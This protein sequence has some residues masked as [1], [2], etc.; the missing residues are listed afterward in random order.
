MVLFLSIV[1]EAYKDPL[2]YYYVL[3]STAM[4]ASSDDLETYDYPGQAQLWDV[5]AIARDTT[6]PANNQD[7]VVA[8]GVQCT[9]VNKTLFSSAKDKAKIT[10]L[11]S[12]GQGCFVSVV[13]DGDPSV[14]A[15]SAV[16]TNQYSVPEISINNS[17]GCT[18]RIYFGPTS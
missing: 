4:R 18:Y 3:P 10:G 12:T 8:A 13:K 16:A 17:S 7:V 6:L 15:E 1:A 2:R 14:Q 5:Y 11:P 9:H